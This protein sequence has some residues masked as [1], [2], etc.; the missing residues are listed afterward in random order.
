MVVVF[1]FDNCD[2]EV[3]LVVEDVVGT[4]LFTTGMKFPPDDNSPVGKGDLFT[5]LFV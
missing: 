1:C 5:Y 3:G 4:L 2:R